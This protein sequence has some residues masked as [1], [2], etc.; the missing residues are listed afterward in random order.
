MRIW[1]GTACLALVVLTL[2]PGAVAQRVKLQVTSVT[3]Q[4]S[5]HDTP[6]K[7]KVNAGDRIAFRDML[8]NRR[9][10]FG[11]K[12]GKAVAHDVGTM[13]YTSAVD[14]TI[15]VVVTFEGIGTI[16]YHGLFV[17]R[18]DGTTVIPVTGGT[19]AFAGAT[20]TVTLGKGTTRAP[21][22]FDL[23]V[24]QNVDLT[25]TAVA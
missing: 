23:S 6:P 20:G 18:S 1:A 16:H 14:P 22:V 2:A 12:K 11:R 15:D 24:P 25:A 8:L 21:A 13:V 9:P 10:L 17:P 4:A 3:T 7:G 19:G 5:A